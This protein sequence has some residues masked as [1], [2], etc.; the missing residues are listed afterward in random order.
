MGPGRFSL[1][2]ATGH[3]FNRRWM[4]IVGLMSTI[5]GAAYMITTR[6]PPEPAPDEV[7]A[8][9]SPKGDEDATEPLTEQTEA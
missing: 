5:A 6:R 2:Q 4:A 9:E 8:A 1:D 7:N 3:L